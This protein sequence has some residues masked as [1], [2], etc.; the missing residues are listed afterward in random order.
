MQ[1]TKYLLLFI[2]LVIISNQSFS[3]DKIDLLILNK[4]YNE[5]LLQIDNQ[6]NTNPSAKLYFKKGV[7]YKKTQNYQEALN[8]FTEALQLEPDNTEILS[9][10]A[11]GLTVLGN[12]W[13][14]VLYF[15]KAI[16]LAPAN[17]T[18]S[19]K[20]GRVYINLKEYKNAY[21]VFSGIYSTDSTNVYWNKQFAFCSFKVFKRKQ[22]V[23]LYEKVLEANPRDYGSYSNLIHS[24]SRKK[25][26]D[27]IMAILS[28]G[29]EQFPGDTGLILERA[30]FF[31]KSKSYE[32]AMF[33]F[34]EYFKA[35]GDSIFEIIMNYGISTYFA[36]EINS[37][38]EIFQGLY[39]ISP[40][41]PFVMY[42]ISLCNKKMKNFEEAEK[43]MQWAIEATV[44]DYVGEMYHHLGQIFGQQRMFKESVNALEK[45]YE[46]NPKKYEILF[47]IATTYEEFNSNKTLAL[48]YYQI[49]LK[50][51]GV[52]GQN[53]NY[54]LDRISKIK[55]DMFFNE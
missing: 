14:A 34:E 22:A 41:D 31:F 36:K 24:Y 16:E 52:E 30:N 54:T 23:S 4:K 48:N 18:L 1:T 40:N 15:K 29:L 13:D 47:E 49:Y 37:A 25:D 3:Q 5:A 19:G 7:V 55:E 39:R 46:L 27:K 32:P 44:P 10:M 28:K 43:M 26:P 2:L 42:Y 17:L 53:T 33:E 20:L 11:E 50:E 21:N 6:L 51:S 38:M 8:S 45:S 35:D 9:E 12:N